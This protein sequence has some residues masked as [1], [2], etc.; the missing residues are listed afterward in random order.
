MLVNVAFFAVISQ[1]NNIRVTGQTAVRKG[2]Q[3][4]PVLG[5]SDLVVWRK[6]LLWKDQHVMLAKQ[7]IQR[8]G[9]VLTDRTQVE[10]FDHCPKGRGHFRYAHCLSLLQTSH[11]L[12]T[13]GRILPL[14]NLPPDGL[15]SQHN[16]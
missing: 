14:Q 13:S 3:F 2:H 10:V 9:L 1:L 4:T 6:L 8:R 15:H 16:Q 11:N 7:L 5:E 12:T